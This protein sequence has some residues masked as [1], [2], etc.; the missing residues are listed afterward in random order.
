MMKKLLVLALVL[1]V[2]GFANAGLTLTKAV[3]GKSLAITGA[4]ND[5]VFLGLFLVTVGG[6]V[7][8]AMIY[9]GTGAENGLVTDADALAFLNGAMNGKGILS[10]AI[11]QYR[12]VNFSDATDPF[13]Y[14][15]GSLATVTA[16]SVV[17]VFAFDLDGVDLGTGQGDG[18][19]TL[20]P[21]PMTMLL[22]G[23][24]GLFLRK[25]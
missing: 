20:V 11:S 19:Y 7:D 3:D 25:K 18:A 14:P 12:V 21:E 22:L 23:L 13:T 17:K 6:T 1:A 16:N 15:N 4:G 24:G 2:A 9:P 5:G 10:G 8:V